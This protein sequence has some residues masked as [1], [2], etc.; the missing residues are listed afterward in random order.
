MSTK[1]PRNPPGQ[2]PNT[3][4]PL[5]P[6]GVPPGSD[7]N[8]NYEAPW[9]GIALADCVG[10]DPEP[11]LCPSAQIVTPSLRS[12][13]TT[14]YKTSVPYASFSPESPPPSQRFP[15]QHL[16]STRRAKKL[17]TLPSTTARR[18]APQPGTG[19]RRAVL[20]KTLPTQRQKW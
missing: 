15:N 16:P 14:A 5:P 18:R 9:I 3:F 6:R 8:R 4:L 11:C 20:C 10:P 7:N 1:R 2:M 17:T 12:G 19:I 13:G